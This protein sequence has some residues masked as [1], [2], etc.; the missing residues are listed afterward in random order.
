VS[1]GPV[2]M[3]AYDDAVAERY[4]MIRAWPVLPLHLRPSHTMANLARRLASP[5]GR[6]G[7]LAENQDSVLLLSAELVIANADPVLSTHSA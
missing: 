4:P 1:H 2:A 7:V 6:D 5:E 3:F